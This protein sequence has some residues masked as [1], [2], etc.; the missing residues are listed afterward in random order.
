MSKYTAWTRSGWIVLDD[1]VQPDYL[2]HVYLLDADADRPADAWDMDWLE[3][4]EEV[5][6][7]LGTVVSRL[8]HG[9]TGW[10]PG[11]ERNLEEVP[12]GIRLEVF[13]E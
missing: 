7:F 8:I 2:S 5:I 6:H 12:G 9:S 11:H 3:E 4:P 10:L 1:D 13:V